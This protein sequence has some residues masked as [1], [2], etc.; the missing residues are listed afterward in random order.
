MAM[1]A[2]RSR[3]STGVLPLS[4][5]NLANVFRASEPAGPRSDSAFGRHKVFST[6]RI[7]G[8]VISVSCRER[9]TRRGGRG[10]LNGLS[11]VLTS[12]II[13]GRPGPTVDT[14]RFFLAAN[15]ASRST[16]VIVVLM[17]AYIVLGMQSRK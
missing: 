14:T 6:S 2:L 11:S 13:A 3:I 5:R 15:G 8:E 10:G 4:A 7:S 17:D 1:N 9:L 12:R 16:G